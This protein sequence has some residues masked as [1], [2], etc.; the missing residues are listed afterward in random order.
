MLLRACILPAARLQRTD[1]ASSPSMFRRAKLNTVFT[2]IDGRP[3]LGCLNSTVFDGMVFDGC[4]FVMGHNSNVIAGAL[5]I[6]NSTFDF[7]QTD[8][9]MAGNAINVYAQTGKMVFTDNTFILNRNGQRGIN[10]TWADWALGEYDAS[11]VTIS[12]NRFEGVASDCA[13]R[14]VAT[15]GYWTNCDVEQ[16]QADNDLN[17]G[18]IEVVTE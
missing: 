4:T 17:G 11:D 16:L 14:I 13:I 5:T 7:S 10:L 1:T 18:A 3:T 12:G 6:R 2:G 15:P 9:D 8:E